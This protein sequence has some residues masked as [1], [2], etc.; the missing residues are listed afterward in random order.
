MAKAEAAA[1]VDAVAARWLGCEFS[2][3]IGLHYEPARLLAGGSQW[4]VKDR[5]WKVKERQWKT[6]NA[7]AS[8]LH[9]LRNL[10]CRLVQ[11]GHVLLRLF[12]L[13]R[14]GRWLLRGL[15]L[16]KLNGSDKASDKDSDKD[17]ERL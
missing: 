10:N 16:L 13:W 12:L 11:L 14:V 3:E 2:P 15:L 6:H 7:K 4:K 17:S 1:A 5:Q 9:L 8:A